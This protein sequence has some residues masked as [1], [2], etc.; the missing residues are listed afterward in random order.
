MKIDAYE[1]GR[2]VYRDKTYTSDL[3]IFPDR[4]NPSWWRLKG[5]LLQIEDLNEILEEEPDILI[6][7]TGAMGVMK[8]PEELEKRLKE[9][10]I[11][12]HVERTGKAVEIFNSANKTKKTIAAFHLTC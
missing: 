5:H 8:V 4:V 12:L 6:I 3:I 10:D 9:K 2:M 7:G 11:E 1:F